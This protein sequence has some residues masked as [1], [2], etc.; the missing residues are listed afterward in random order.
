VVAQERLGAHA[1]I[2]GPL[3]G[4]IERRAYIPTLL[5]PQDRLAPEYA[6]LASHEARWEPNCRTIDTPSGQL[7]RGRRNPIPC[8]SR[9][10]HVNA[11]RPLRL[12]VGPERM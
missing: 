2:S 7:M 3:H 6:A 11:G 12:K 9:S 8:S 10:L 4:K 5:Y 1:G